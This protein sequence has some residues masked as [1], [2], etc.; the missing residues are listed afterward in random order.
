MRIACL[1]GLIL[2]VALARPAAADVVIDWNNVLLDAIR[3][4]N[5]NPPRASRAMAMVHGA[6]FD[7]VNTIDR[8]H[9]PY[10]VQ[11]N[12]SP[13]GNREAA[14]AQ[15]AHDVLVNLF[16]TQQATFDSALTTSLSAIP[17]GTSKAGG[18]GCHCP[19]SVPGVYGVISVL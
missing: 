6:V 5:V 10:H 4:N 17:D 19:G 1:G 11:L 13:G 2:V 3:T 14:A 9:V 15:A 8:T 12:V 7:A 16:P 18:V